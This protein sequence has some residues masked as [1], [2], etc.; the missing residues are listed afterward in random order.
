LYRLLLDSLYKMFEYNTITVRIYLRTTANN[1]SYWDYKTVTITLTGNQKT[2]HINVSG[3]W[4]RSK[5]WANVNGTWKRCV[6]WI[7]INGTWK[8]CI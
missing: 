7:N 1:L 3:T 6:R 8:R 2:G 5:K 4:K